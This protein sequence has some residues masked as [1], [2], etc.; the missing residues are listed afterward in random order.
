MKVATSLENI[1]TNQDIE[2][3]DSNLYLIIDIST[4]KPLNIEP[5]PRDNNVL[6]RSYLKKKIERQAPDQIADKL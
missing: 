3:N 2:R 6:A 1:L 5:S 4:F